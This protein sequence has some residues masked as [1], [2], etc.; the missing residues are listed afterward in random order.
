MSDFLTC[1]NSTFT[2][3]YNQKSNGVGTLKLAKVSNNPLAPSFPNFPRHRQ[4]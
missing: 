1:M 4:Y 2:I 3:L